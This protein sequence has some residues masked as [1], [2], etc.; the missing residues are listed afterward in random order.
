M[1]LL[2]AGGGTGGHLFPG[3]A[4]AEE[5]LKREQGNEV[6]FIGTERGLERKVLPGLGYRLRTIDVEGLKGKGLRSMIGILKLPRS[7]AQSMA[8]INEFSPH[9]VLGVGG[10]ASGPAVLAAFLK[11]VPA[12]I[13][14]Q[15]AIPGETNK[16]LAR[17]A[18]K[19]FLSFPDNGW[20]PPG[21]A[22]VTGNPIRAG[23]LERKAAA[24]KD[25]RFT[26]L[27]FGGSQGAHRINQAMIEALGF[28][29]ESLNSIRII[30]QTGGEDLEDVRRAYERESRE[31]LIAEVLPFISDMSQAYG[32]ADLLVCRAGATS[33][34]EITAC[35]KAAVLIPFPFAV[36]DHQTR[37][38]EALES[39]GAAVLFPQKELD[40]KKL[41]GVIID[42]FGHPEKIRA[43]E[44][45]SS[46][47]G[48]PDAAR[49]VVDECIGI[50]KGQA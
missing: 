32:R 47:M 34:A 20:V 19:V 29:G 6:L 46:R 14:E 4:V 11:G 42:L 50:I 45:A 13:A 26:I 31:G 22:V 38:A 17:L 24:E 36:A 33:I 27:V 18:K 16:V 37:N 15:N 28:L 39:A 10:Y 25:G 7:L 12:A 5:F 21:K 30:H 9:M 48:H 40:G 41:A 1:R 3:V 2:I 43:M 35:G 8:A 49:R 44:Q 23:L